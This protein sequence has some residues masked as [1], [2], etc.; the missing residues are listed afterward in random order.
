MNKDIL[1]TII[2]LIIVSFMVGWLLSFFDITPVD[3]WTSLV[4]FL[5][6]LF[7]TLAGFAGDALIYVIIGGA[8]VVPLY[9][10][11]RIM[12]RRQHPPDK[13]PRGSTESD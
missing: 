7:E 5:S 3:F 2:K 12:K 10:L 13:T 11:S 8:I 4:A 6:G 9:V 1:K